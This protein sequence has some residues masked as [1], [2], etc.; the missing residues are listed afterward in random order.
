MAC[1]KWGAQ[2]ALLHGSRSAEWVQCKPATLGKFCLPAVEP[3]H[4][5]RPAA[6]GWDPA[7]IAR[8]VGFALFG[9]PG[10]EANP[11]FLEEVRWQ[12]NLKFDSLHSLLLLHRDQPGR[13]LAIVARSRWHASGTNVNP[14]FLEAVRW[15]SAGLQQG[16]A[17]GSLSSHAA[18]PQSMARRATSAPALHTVTAS[19]AL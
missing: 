12:S 10:T 13:R 11:T 14:A 6:A 9:V 2:S 4:P 3:T 7:R 18:L 16:F 17:A 1:C 15:H 5:P 19:F 8:R